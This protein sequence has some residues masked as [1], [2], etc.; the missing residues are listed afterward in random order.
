MVC[1]CLQPICLHIIWPEQLGTQE[2][3]IIYI[4]H[5]QQRLGGQ[6]YGRFTP[7]QRRGAVFIG[8]RTIL[9]K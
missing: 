3:G 6:A 9:L 8:K 5:D 7:A 4:H 1:L 2:E